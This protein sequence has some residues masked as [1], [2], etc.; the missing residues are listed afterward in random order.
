MNDVPA[1]DPSAAYDYCRGSSNGYIAVK[2]GGKMGVIKIEKDA[3]KIVVDFTYDMICQ[4]NGGT[5]LAYNGKNWGSLE[6]GTL[7]EITTDAPASETTTLPPAVTTPAEVS[8]G[9]FVVND[10]ESN[11]RT[12]PDTDKDDNI[13]TALNKGYKITAYEKKEGSNGSEW[14][15][16]EYE[17]KEAW[18][19]SKKLDKAE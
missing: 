11:I 6:I 19:S 10:D 14:V 9:T 17:G 3:Y 8:I 18:I 5:F 1:D 7:S 15:R 4:G 13:I 12:S 2:K 16:F